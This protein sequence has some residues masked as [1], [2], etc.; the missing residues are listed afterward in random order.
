M[1]THV[2]YP[3]KGCILYG[4]FEVIEIS[5]EGNTAIVLKCDD[6][7]AKRV[8]AVKRFKKKVITEEMKKKIAEEPNLGV[9]SDYFVISE[10]YFNENGFHH[11]VMPHI[12]GQC[13]GDILESGVIIEP[14]TAVNIILHITK[15]VD[16]LHKINYVSTDLKPENTMITAEGRIV[17]IDNTFCEKKGSKAKV[18]LGT[19]PYAPYELLN[20]KRLH[21]STDTFSIVVILC[22][23]LME[24]SEFEKI[25]KSWKL[26]V[27][28]GL[29]PDISHISSKYPE[30][31]RIADRAL[32]PNP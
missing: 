15:A 29:K 24:V 30:I 26:E 23:L 14:I 28:R 19:I 21:A 13:L 4:R 18:S 3:D 6:K 8:M 22:E 20:K 12:D 9:K 17:L 27:E 25:S 7:V 2:K 5:G 1:P 16:E 10:Q 31:G 11:L 32:E